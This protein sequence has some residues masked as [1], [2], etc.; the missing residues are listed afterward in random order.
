MKLIL[1]LQPRLLKRRWRKS[2]NWQDTLSRTVWKLFK[3]KV[4]SMMS[5]L[6]S[7]KLRLLEEC[8]I[9]IPDTYNTSKDKR[10]STSKTNL[11]TKEKEEESQFWLSNIIEE[12]R[13]LGSLL[14]NLRRN[15][16]SSIRSKKQLPLLLLRFP[17]SSFSLNRLRRLSRK[18]LQTKRKLRK[19][20]L[21]LRADSKRL[22]S[23]LPRSEKILK[24]SR[25][26]MRI[27]TRFLSPK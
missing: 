8:T 24:E 13:Q 17:R 9:N 11:S 20:L 6:W 26:N 5:S 25:I 4:R 16:K 2:E 7:L 23:K 21:I 12:L 19:N 10:R 18:R 22:S 15:R 1:K 3:L 27:L 14:N